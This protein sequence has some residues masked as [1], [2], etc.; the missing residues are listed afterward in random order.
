MI[1][2][3]LTAP[4][5]LSASVLGDVI[6]FF[7]SQ[8]KLPSLLVSFLER[9]R[10]LTRVNG[11]VCKP[12]N[13]TFQMF[14]FFF[15]AQLT[16]ISFHLTGVQFTLLVIVNHWRNVLPI[17]YFSFKINTYIK[18]TLELSFEFNQTNFSCIIRYTIP[19]NVKLF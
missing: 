3:R 10:V 1:Y 18:S 8:G 2:F 5:Y 17:I 9:R 4:S 16:E 7:Y 6:Y 19:Q 13:D 11:E 15:Q 14:S 12:G